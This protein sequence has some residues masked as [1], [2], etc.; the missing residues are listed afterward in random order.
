MSSLISL[1]DDWYF[2]IFSLE[3][4]ILAF[5]TQSLMSL[6]LLVTSTSL[7]KVVFFTW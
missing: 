1:D 2:E 3:N 7:L 4:L 5:S 6:Y